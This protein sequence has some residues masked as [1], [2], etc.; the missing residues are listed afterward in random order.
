VDSTQDI[1][2]RLELYEQNG[3]AKLYYALNRKAN[4]MAELL[5]SRSL[6][7]LDLGDPKDKTFERM[8]IIWNDASTIITAISGLAMAIG[9]TGN[10]EKDV[11]KGN[12]IMTPESIANQ[13]GDNK[14]HDV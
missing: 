12:L 1:R 13:F 6:N 4:E 5:N 2:K 10:E 14:A 11:N 9:V 8:K 7:S 3:P